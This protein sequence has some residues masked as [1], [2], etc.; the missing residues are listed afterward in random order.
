MRL[1]PK[2]LENCKIL[3]FPYE[4]LDKSLNGYYYLF[5]SGTASTE[6]NKYLKDFSTS[7]HGHIR[8]NAIVVKASHSMEPVTPVGKSALI[9]VPKEFSGLA[10]DRNHLI[11]H[12]N[13]L[14]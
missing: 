11:Q 13:G 2:W 14:K 8:G 6:T 5:S 4:G 9:G 7:S 3:G 1:G 12:I 10:G